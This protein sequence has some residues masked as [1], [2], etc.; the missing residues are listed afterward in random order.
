MGDI[1]KMPMA[2]L[3]RVIRRVNC[4]YKVLKLITIKLN[5][6]YML[7]CLLA[8]R[9]IPHFNEQWLVWIVLVETFEVLY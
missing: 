1:R 9:I 5:V 7:L 8:N 2:N 4:N 6:L 3:Q